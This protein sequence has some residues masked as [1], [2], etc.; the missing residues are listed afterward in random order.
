MIS[1]DTDPSKQTSGIQLIAF[2]F[3]A[4]GLAP[5]AAFFSTGILYQLWSMSDSDALEWSGLEPFFF[6]ITY[7]AIATLAALPIVLILNWVQKSRCLSPLVLAAVGFGTSSLSAVAYLSLLVFLTEPA[8]DIFVGIP[9]EN[10]HPPRSLSDF[11]Y[12]VRITAVD[13]AITYGAWYSIIFTFLIHVRASP[14]N[15]IG[16]ENPRAMVG[17]FLALSCALVLASAI[18]FYALNAK[19]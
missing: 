18:L 15:A 4:A 16:S 19:A 12:F 1:S 17:S 5:V 13:G 6:M 8:E 11:A 2:H 9:T 3:L 10:Y 7:W 14:I